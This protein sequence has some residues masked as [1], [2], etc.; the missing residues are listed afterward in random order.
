MKTYY[1]AALSLLAGVA[2]ADIYNCSGVYVGILL[3]EKGAGL[4]GVTFHNSPTATSGSYYLNFIGWTSYDNK[5]VLGV[6]TTAKL[7]GQP[8]NIKTE[9][10][11]ECSIDTTWQTLK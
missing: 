5:P 7:A 6:L 4:S 3:V 1:A 11:G 9:A 8:V 2:N 10:T